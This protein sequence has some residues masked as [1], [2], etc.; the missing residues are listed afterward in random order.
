MTEDQGLIQL[1]IRLQPVNYFNRATVFFFRVFAGY[2]SKGEN[3]NGESFRK[4]D[5][6]AI[7]WTWSYQ[8]TTQ[9]IRNNKFEQLR[10]VSMI[11]SI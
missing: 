4:Q 9:V 5:K 11:I 2:V 3:S 10:K 8:N 7:M 6:M 1:N